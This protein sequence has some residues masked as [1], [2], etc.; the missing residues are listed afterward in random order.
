MKKI[1]WF[2]LLMCMVVPYVSAENGVVIASGHPDWAPAMYR[3]NDKIVG[4]APEMVTKIFS[5]LELKVE[6]RYAGSWADVQELGKRGEIDVI[7]A[8]YK[9]EERQKYF[10]YSDAYLNDNISLFSKQNIFYKNPQSLEGY[11][12]A[13]SRGD[14]YGQYIDNFLKSNRSIITVYDEPKVAMFSV[15]SGRSDLFLYSTSSGEKIIKGAMGFENIKSEVV[16][17]M[18]FYILI[19][20]K[21]RYASLMPQVNKII[22]ELKSKG[23]IPT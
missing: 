14:S 13:V 15:S 22:E 3:A 17:N 6:S 21:S 20:K 8:A 11:N 7:V 10:E 9:T 18:P 1:F 4:I 19:S 12:I 16:G 23:E 5:K 2:L